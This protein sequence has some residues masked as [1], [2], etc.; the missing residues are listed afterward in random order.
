MPEWRGQ[1]GML[2]D[3]LFELASQTT[4]DVPP[5]SVAVYLSG[6][7]LAQIIGK[8]LFIQVMNDL[9]DIKAMFPGTHIV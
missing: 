9:W 2:W 8:S 5:D 7:N 3:K 4:P 6:S 1:G